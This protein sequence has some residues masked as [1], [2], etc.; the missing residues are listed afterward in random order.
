MKYVK[1]ISDY[2]K[3]AFEY[4]IAKYLSSNLDTS[5]CYEKIKNRDFLVRNFKP[6]NDFV[7]YTNALMCAFELKSES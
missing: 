1:I 7:I 5:I 3:N 2:S 6:I 4:E